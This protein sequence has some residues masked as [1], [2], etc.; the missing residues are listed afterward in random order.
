MYAIVDSEVSV[1][2]RVSAWESQ[3]II[4]KIRIIEVVL[5]CDYV[6]VASNY[7]TLTK[8]WDVNVRFVDIGGIDDYHC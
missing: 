3:H 4:T 8:S 5:F 1:P 7:I 6:P 2:N